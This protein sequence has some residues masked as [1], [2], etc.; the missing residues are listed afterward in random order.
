MAYKFNPFNKE[1]QDTAGQ[2]EITLDA[3]IRGRTAERVLF[4]TTL[5]AVKRIA[6]ITP[7]SDATL[8]DVAMDCA[9]IE[10][11][12]DESNLFD[13]EDGEEEGL[14]NEDSLDYALDAIFAFAN[15]I[16]ISATSQKEMLSDARDIAMDE[17]QAFASTINEL[18]ADSMDIAQLVSVAMDRAEIKDAFYDGDDT[19]LD[20]ITMDWS[21]H[22]TNDKEAL[23][24]ANEK[25]GAIKGGKT[26]KRGNSKLVSVPCNRTIN[27]V[28][29]KGF[30]FYPKE[31]VNGADYKPRSKGRNGGV[32]AHIKA[33]MKAMRAKKTPRSYER[34][35][36]NMK[37][38]KSLK[39]PSAAHQSA[40]KPM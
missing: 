4:A 28:S 6:S 9:G 32:Y 34:M 17:L 16:G 15:A 35:V 33:H 31:L 14:T 3:V 36:E 8:F 21:F 19:S 1:E 7:D 29:K 20:A 37:A 24:E 40:N 27:G 13:E 22:R 39:K 5:D 26:N 2:E 18:T 30:C 38:T 12:E 11:E 25:I 23:K 10:V